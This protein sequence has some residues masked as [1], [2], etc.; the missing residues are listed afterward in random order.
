M[1]GALLATFLFFLASPVL[2]AEA[3]VATEIPAGKA[4]TIR[5]RS[6]PDGASVAV[7][8][9]STGRLLVA[10]VAMKQ[11]KEP[12]SGS[13]ALFRGVVQDKLSFRVVITQAD[14]YLLVLSNRAGRQAVKVEAE[15]RAVRRRP[16]PAPK[17]YSPRPEKA[18]WSPR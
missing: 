11:L 14:D 1:P 8:I 7:R 5:I 15:I 12:S 6:L 10:F 9:A 4:K 3:A 18:S 2:A 17:D 16:K 13:K